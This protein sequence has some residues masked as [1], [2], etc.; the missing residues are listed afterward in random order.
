VNPNNI[1]Y[2]SSFTPSSSSNYDAN[3]RLNIQD[4]VYDGAGNLTQIGS[5]AFQFQ[6]DAENRMTSSTYNQTTTQ[7]VYDGFGRRVS[8][9]VGGQTTTFV[10]DP[11]GNL[12]QQYDSTAPPAGT[13]Y[14]VADALGSTRLVTDGSGTAL[15]CYDYL[16]FGEELGVGATGRNDPCFTNATY[17]N[18]FPDLVSQKFTGKERDQETGLDFFGARYYGGAQGRFTSPDPGNVSG[19]NHMDDPQSWN[20]YSYVRNN[21]LKLTDPDGFDYSV[22]EVDSRGKDFN[23]GTIT[24]DKDF[25]KYAKSQGWYIKSGGLYDK[26]GNQIGSAH[27]FDG[28]RQRSDIAGAQFL[29]N[30]TGPVVNALATATV[31]FAMIATGAEIAELAGGSELTTLGRITPT[32]VIP[33]SPGQIAQMERVLAQQGRPGVQKALQSLEQ[34]LAEHLDKIKAAKDAGG[35]TSSMEREVRNFRQLI[36]AARKVLGR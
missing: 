16:P 13:E 2:P 28:D 23:C 1:P 33:P 36:E 26:S 11:L 20:G 12:A 29:V 3:N 7:Y 6:Y 21:P 10:Y 9:A 22:C 15:R 35:Y 17:P 31:T 14:F 34:R 24:N 30:Q 27:W 4:P 18:A 25:E 8:K 19:L 5:S 32:E